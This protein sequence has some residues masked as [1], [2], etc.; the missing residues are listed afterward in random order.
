MLRGKAAGVSS[1]CYQVGRTAPA[2]SRGPRR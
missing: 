2:N 1:P